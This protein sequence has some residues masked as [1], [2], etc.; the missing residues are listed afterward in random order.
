MDEHRLGAYVALS[1]ALPPGGAGTIQRP[2]IQA[3]RN[4]ATRVQ[5]ERH[6]AQLAQVTTDW[7]RA[8]L[9][10]DADARE[11]LVHPAGLNT[12]EVWQQK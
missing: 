1:P 8:N 11:R 4:E 7:W 5:E 3:R 10:G 12:G 2:F 6:H 9:L